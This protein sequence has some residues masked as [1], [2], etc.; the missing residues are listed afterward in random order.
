[1]EVVHLSSL[2]VCSPRPPAAPVAPL[3][4]PA[5]F[6]HL[7][8]SSLMPSTNPFNPQPLPFSYSSRSRPLS[9]S[10]EMSVSPPS[11]RICIK[12]LPSHYLNPPP[13][14]KG[15][16]DKLASTIKK[17]FPQVTITDIYVPKT[18]S[19]IATR[20]SKGGN[21]RDTPGNVNVRRI[22]F[23][24]FSTP[25]DAQIVTNHFNSTFFDTTK[26]IVEIALNKNYVVKDS[27]KDGRPWSKHTSGTSK[28]NA[29]NGDTPTLTVLGKNDESCTTHFE[30]M[31]EQDRIA[32]RKKEEYVAA[33][34]SRGDGK[35]WKNDDGDV[36]RDN[37]NVDVIGDSDSDD[38]SVQEANAIGDNNNDNNDNNKDDEEDDEEDD[39]ID[40]LA[41]AKVANKT[42]SDLDFFRS[43]VVPK[44]DLDD[45]CNTRC[46][47]GEEDWKAGT[48]ERN[49]DDW[50]EKEMDVVDDG[51]AEAAT[52]T[53]TTTLSTATAS[54][55][56]STATSTTRLFIRNLP[57][58]ASE[59]DLNSTVST[60][61]APT[62][63]HIPLD[64]SGNRKGYAFCTFKNESDAT[65]VIERLDG[66]V[67]MGRLI[68]VMYAKDHVGLDECDGVAGDA[69]NIPKSKLT[70]KQ[71]MEIERKKKAGDELGWNS[72]YVR[73]DTVVAA[74]ADELNVSKGDILDHNENGMAVRL[75]LGETK[76]LEDNKAYF[77]M[78]R[79]NVD[80]DTLKSL[81]NN[82]HVK[83]SG[84]VILVKNL[85]Y[86]TTED[87][88]TK[89]FSNYGTVNK[90]LLPPSRALA[91]IE[92]EQPGEARKAFKKLAY[93][94][95]KHVPL[96]LE[97]APEG[98]IQEG[99]HDTTTSSV[100]ESSKSAVDK[101][102][103]EEDETSGHAIAHSI[104]VKNL[105][106]TTTEDSLAH[107]FESITPKKITAVKIP[108]KIAPEGS[109]AAGQV[110]SLGYG[111]V[112]FADAESARKAIKEGDKKNLD[113]HLIEV[114]RSDKAIAKPAVGK[115]V[116]NSVTKSKQTKL[117]VKNLPFE[118]SREE[119]MQLFGNFG[120]LKKTTIPK[121]FDGTSRGFAFVEFLTAQEASNAK[122]ALEKTHL[123]GRH[124][125]IGY[126]DDKEDLDTLRDKAKRD[127]G[128]KDMAAASRKKRKGGNG[129]FGG[130]G[131]GG[132]DDFE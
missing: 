89:I 122:A 52:T 100:N 102:D 45:D 40:P 93:T 53:T 28:Y 117:M 118:A 115:K 12:N 111:F 54:T 14:I 41:N 61:A 84:V 94:K 56:T 114:K 10:L 32:V 77:K 46:S 69:M 131:G 62:L 112:E 70:Y 35:F 87:E 15:G 21:K 81:D 55:S 116:G 97:W 83:R 30:K 73:S 29:T 80:F 68:H 74:L 108:T 16:N 126:A 26:V 98:I 66:E 59:N 113:G 43:K 95:F 38:D 75:A 39:D 120:T 24:G 107:F 17:V 103:E 63:T 23:V 92:Y 1:M 27:D 50:G 99:D 90:L 119:L 121:K 51:M 19:D 31:T 109:K 48:R 2:S 129:K 37:G 7:K 8:Q 47:G 78:H 106:F 20:K 88:L 132:D 128:N 64:D 82:K 25:S 58:T 5:Y 91:I 49:G 71:K 9:L 33:M 13:S 4:H 127:L 79:V 124:L 34:M 57:F 42:M 3:N 36:I 104:F 86:E 72:S 76:L 22:A 123:Y 130:G 67:F 85:P 11:S 96:Y 60:I 101:E 44:D 65:R 125:V 105:K 110:Q 6:P 18:S